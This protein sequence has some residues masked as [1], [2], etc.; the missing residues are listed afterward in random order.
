M[1]Q[2]VCWSWKSAKD[3]SKIPYQDCNKHFRFGDGKQ[4]IASKAF[5]IPANVGPH[6]VDT[7][8]HIVNT[9]IPP[10]LL[11]ISYEKKD[12]SNSN[13]QMLQSIF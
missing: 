11:L 3:K 4:F 8:T 12:K 2:W 7:K 6:K 1:V 5:T 9:D 13:S 10:P